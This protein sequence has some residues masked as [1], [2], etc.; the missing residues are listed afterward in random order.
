LNDEVKEDEMYRADSLN[1]EEMNEY[2]IL[3]ES[4]KERNQ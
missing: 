1:G 2:G 3:V 4:Q